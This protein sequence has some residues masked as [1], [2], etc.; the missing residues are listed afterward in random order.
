MS[1][2]AIDTSVTE[3]VKTNKRANKN[4]L[5]ATGCDWLKNYFVTRPE[6]KQKLKVCQDHPKSK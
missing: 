1:A 4:E 2:T 6:E 5:L 3:L